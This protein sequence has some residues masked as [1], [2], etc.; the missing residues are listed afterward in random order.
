MRNANGMGCVC[1]LSGKRRKPWVFKV[2]TGWERNDDTGRWVQQVK[3]MG[4]Y[5]TRKEAMA[6]QASWILNHDP[7]SLVETPTFAD[8]YERFMEEREKAGTSE[9]TLKTYYGSYK[10][11]SALYNREINSIRLEE[12]QKIIDQD[13]TAGGNIRLKVLFNGM[14]SYAHKNDYVRDNKIT[15]LRT[16]DAGPKSTA[17]YRFTQE[18][19]AVLWEHV[20]NDI[21]DFLLVSCYTGMRPKEL[22]DARKEDVDVE[23]RSLHIPKGKTVN[24]KRTVP[25]PDKVWPIIERRMAGNDSEYI[26]V[27]DQNRIIDFTAD[28]YITYKATMKQWGI[29]DYVHPEAGPQE[30]LPYDGRHTFQSMWGDLQLDNEMMEYLVAHTPKSIGKR[31]YTHYDIE[32]L[33]A[34]MNKL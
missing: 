9:Q 21:A 31:V 2:T 28:K 1:Q 14:W 6:A 20:G 23:K 26:M 4:T 5:A 8:I 7:E 29:L 17:H 32:V 3:V 10:K 11:C 12:L 22:R 33:R 24:A 25:F 18:E 19:L 15:Y 27:G 16:K 13:P 34:E 30:H